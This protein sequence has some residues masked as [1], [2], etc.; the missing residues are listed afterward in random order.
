MGENVLSIVSMQKY[1]KPKKTN[2]NKCYSSVYF[3]LV[4]SKLVPA[5]SMSIENW[6]MPRAD[7]YIFKLKI[8]IHVYNI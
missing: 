5:N 2:P 8:S 4:H 1:L 7:F 3:L 6:T